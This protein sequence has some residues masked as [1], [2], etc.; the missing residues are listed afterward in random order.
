MEQKLLGIQNPSSDEIDL[1]EPLNGQ[2]I[3]LLFFP[4]QPM[5]DSYIIENLTDFSSANLLG[6]GLIKNIDLDLGGLHILPSFNNFDEVSVNCIHLCDNKIFNLGTSYT[7][8]P[9]L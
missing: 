3:A 1:F 9:D 2:I 4:N 5:S 8:H 7:I 6:F